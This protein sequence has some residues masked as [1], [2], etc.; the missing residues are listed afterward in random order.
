MLRLFSTVRA[1]LLPALITAMGVMLVTAGLLSYA[2]PATAGTAV[3]EP[4]GIE[5]LAPTEAPSA[6]IGIPSPSAVASASA[7]PGAS[8]TVSATPAVRAVATRVAIPALGIDLPV[9]KGPDGYP[10]CNVAMYMTTKTA[11]QPDA[12]GQP[13]EGRATYIYAH[14]QDGMFGP[15][16][17]LAIPDRNGRKMLGMIVQVYA[18]D[19]RLH[20]YEIR[21]VRLHQR[22]LD[23]AL[24][25]T[26]EE[27]WLQTSEGPS[28][29]PGKTQLRALPISVGQA[30]PTD[31]HPEAKPVRCD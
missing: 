4:P 26:S 13:G 25:A 15:I 3:V 14:A 1:R 29:T 11:T 2:D 23:D 22:D 20:L 27:L 6:T 7:G 18:S 31:A 12:F 17:E 5:T 24:G 9:I 28:G 30:D 10:P 16:Y 8:P 19:D 21:E